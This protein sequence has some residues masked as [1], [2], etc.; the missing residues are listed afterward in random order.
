MKDFAK[1]LFDMVLSTAGIVLL[2]PVAAAISLVLFLDMREFIF[3]IQE[4]P[5]KRGN[6]F[7]M[8]KFK[9]MRTRHDEKGSLLPD[10]DR[11]SIL[12]KII[13]S[14]SL[15]EIPELWNVLRGDMSIVGPRPLLPVYLS[16]YS[17]EQ[18][19]RHE[20][21]P[22]IT[23][24]AQVN[25]RN[26]ISWEKKLAYDSWYVDHWDLCLDLKIILMTVFNVIRMEGLNK[27]GYVSM[28]EF[29]G[30]TSSSNGGKE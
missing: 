18:S 16:R 12:G 13:R 5:G 23:G 21:K 19:R 26:V 2:A 4:R 9:T 17:P 10:E 20:V 24:W 28:E 27:P 11:L 3:F 6:I 1:R 15:D 7:R 14:T 22:G 8:V 29:M 30:N 25:G